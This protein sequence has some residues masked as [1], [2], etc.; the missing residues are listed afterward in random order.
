M[1]RTLL[2]DQRC[3]VHIAEVTDDGLVVSD[4]LETAELL[5]EAPNWTLD[6]AALVLNG[7]GVLWRYR[8]TTAHWSAKTSTS[9]SPTTTTCPPP[10][11]STCSSLPWMGIS[12]GAPW[13]A[14]RRCA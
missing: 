5:L 8:W 1:P 4:V 7:D 9:P 6:G 11:E 2:P 14:G 13:P 12:T 3:I 10:T